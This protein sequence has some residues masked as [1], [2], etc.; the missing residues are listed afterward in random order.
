[1]ARA[2]A[3]PV[4]YAEMFRRAAEHQAGRLPA[5]DHNLAHT[6]QLADGL[7][8]TYTLAELARDDVPPH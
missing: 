6:R 4:P 1:M 3:A 5:A 2:E 8:I 7:R